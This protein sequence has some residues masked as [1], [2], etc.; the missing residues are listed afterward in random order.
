MESL[1]RIVMCSAL[2]EKLASDFYI[3]LSKK[4]TDNKIKAKLLYIGY[5]SYKH[6]QLLINFTIHKQLP[7][8]DDCRDSFGYVFNKLVSSLD[9]LSSKDRISDDELRV[10]ISSL[11]SFE[12]LVG[13]ELFH[14]MIFVMASKLDLKEK[15][16]LLTLL[17]LLARDE[18]KHEELLKSITTT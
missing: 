11:K 18:E 7:S 14:K 12:N 8:L 5:D 3:E 6:Y 16:E 9:M 17:E 13:E 2:L 1:D 15:D 4:V 10:L